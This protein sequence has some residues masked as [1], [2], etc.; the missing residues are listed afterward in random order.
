MPFRD[1][2]PGT[3]TSA[4][5]ALMREAFDQVCK[6]LNLGEADPRRSE[7]ATILIRLASEGE[8]DLTK[9]AQHELV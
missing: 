4:T 7:L 8:T 6:N 9:R 1:V 2:K 5:L 3:F